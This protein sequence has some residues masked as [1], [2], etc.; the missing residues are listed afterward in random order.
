M[1]AE[2]WPAL[3][4]CAWLPGR[5]HRQQ[6]GWQSPPQPRTVRPADQTGA[7]R[8]Q[9]CCST[10]RRPVPCLAERRVSLGSSLMLANRCRPP[11]AS[12]AARRASW[13]VIS[14]PQGRRGRAAARSG[15]RA[16]AGADNEY[17][18]VRDAMSGGSLFTIGPNDTVDDGGSRKSGRVCCPACMSICRSRRHLR[19]PPPA[20]RPAATPMRGA[21]PLVPYAALTMLVQHRITGLPVVDSDGKVVRAA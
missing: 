8:A 5:A 16:A 7:K 15:V 4:A 1:V 14:A 6:A 13:P 3:L 18:C 10:S 2:L 19:P 12:A 9:S 11:C 21:G 17:R 20:S